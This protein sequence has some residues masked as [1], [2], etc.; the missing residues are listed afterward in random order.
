[1]CW[2]PSLALDGALSFQFH[3][4]QVKP[5]LGIADG[6]VCTNRLAATREVRN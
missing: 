2:G 1:M 3:S 6:S 4:L 5:A